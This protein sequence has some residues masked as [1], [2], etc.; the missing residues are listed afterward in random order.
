MQQMQIIGTAK[1]GKTF[2]DRERLK[3]ENQKVVKG[4]VEQ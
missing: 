4:E 2:E 1:A 3:K